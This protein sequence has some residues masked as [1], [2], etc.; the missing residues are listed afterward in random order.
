VPTTQAPDK[1]YTLDLPVGWIRQFTQDGTLLVSKDGYALQTIG[2]IH[3]KLDNAFPKTRKSASDTMLPSELAELQIAEM[4]TETEQMAVLKVIENEPA[5]L[6]GREGFRLRTTYF[7]R[8]GLE[9]H[10]VT[11]GLADKSGYYRIEYVSPKLYYF[12]RT[13]GDF[14]NVITSFRLA[15][16]QN[17]ASK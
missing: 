17:T 7:T 12:D 10:R 13:F 3:R 14:E 6:D 16:P 2:V 11:Y 1:S 9:I 15:G 4:K 5:T 8:R